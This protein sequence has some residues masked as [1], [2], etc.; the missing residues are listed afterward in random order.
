V[1]TTDPPF[2]V[3]IDLGA[4]GGRAILG[5]LSPSGLLLQ[6]VHRFHYPPRQVEGHLRWPFVSLLDGIRDGIRRA[7]ARASSLDGRI[8][9]I[10][11]DSWGVDYGLLDEAGRL[12]EDPICYRD[13][14]TAGLVEEVCARV[15]REEI[16]SRT[17][18]Q[19]LPLNTLYQ[20]SAHVRGDLPAGSA[21]LLLV[22]DLC[23]HALCGSRVTERTNASTTQ[24]LRVD[25][26]GWDSL[27]F[28]R[29][30]LPRHI[31]PDVV[32]AGT[33][34][35]TLLPQHQTDL[36]VG[37]L[38][39]IAPATHDSASAVAGTPLTPGWAYISSG[40]WSLVGIERH[41]ALLTSRVAQANFTNEA[42]ACG[43]VRF[44]KNVMGLWILE[45]CRRE[46]EAAGLRHDLPTL[47]DKV[48]AV[49]GIA[50]LVFPDH[51]RFFNPPSMMTELRNHLIET[52]Q[53]APDD[54]VLLAKVVL[55][56]LAFRYASVLSTIEALSGRHVPG[57]HIV[58]GGALNRYLNQA[59]A[60]A[61]GRPVLA[62]PAEATATG[63]LVV[64]AIACGEIPSLADA[65]RLIDRSVRP[66]CFTPRPT[67][68]WA[69]AARRYQEI[70][71]RSAA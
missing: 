4:G 45:A 60:D 54:P 49:G 71:E 43:T 63:N 30:G 9:S 22:P 1:S 35:G 57:I 32:P 31:M 15:P 21:Q 38:R 36:S 13:N 2:H 51:P 52:A 59:T 50:G 3:A 24:L 48:D 66:Q 67:A 28:E 64:Q 10:G 23:H 40:T 26:G 25:D 29:L 62:G 11:V 55:D 34:L 68:E 33:E 16:F 5:R 69:A 42:G 56:S 14:R 65:R 61:T 6:D 8:E 53:P 58:G 7:Q 12:L 44:L 70:E 19:F 37:P 27:L 46:W 20:L 47:L 17:G 41:E 39:V 18:I